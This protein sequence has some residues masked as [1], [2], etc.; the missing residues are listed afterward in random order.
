MDCAAAASWKE[1]K[2]ERDNLLRPDG[3]VCRWIDVED[4]LGCRIWNDRHKICCFMFV[5]LDSR[6]ELAPWLETVL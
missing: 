1:R 5:S 2:R 4:V 6:V 3:L